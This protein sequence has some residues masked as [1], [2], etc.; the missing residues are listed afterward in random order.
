MKIWLAI[1]RL[2]NL[3]LILRKIFERTTFIFV[4]KFRNI[5]NDSNLLHSVLFFDKLQHFIE[6]KI[7]LIFSENLKLRWQYLLRDQARPENV[8]DSSPRQA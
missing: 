6:F 3:V 1:I 8:L 2:I 5:V 4:Q 7:C